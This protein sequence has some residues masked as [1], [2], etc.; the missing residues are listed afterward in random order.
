MIPEKM[1]ESEIV[2]RPDTDLVASRVPELRAK[3][4]E[5]AAAGT[6][7]MTLDLAGVQMIDSTGIGLLVAV[8][9]SLTKAGGKVDVINASKDI[10]SL[11]RAMRIHQHMTV[12]GS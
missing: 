5:L 9:N 7:N 2:V 8:H 11:L 4:R 12:S 3:L 10:L 6:R 1:T